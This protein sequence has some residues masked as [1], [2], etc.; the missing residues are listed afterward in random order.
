ML[1][2][3][4]ILYAPMNVLIVRSKLRYSVLQATAQTTVESSGI[5]IGERRTQGGMMLG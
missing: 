4:A 1:E 3:F 5:L 2:I